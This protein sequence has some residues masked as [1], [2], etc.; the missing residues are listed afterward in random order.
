[1]QALALARRGFQVTVLEKDASF[2]ARRQGFGLTL[3][4]GGAALS[5]LG[6]QQAVAEASSWSASHFVFDNFGAIVAFWGPTWWKRAKELAERE[7]VARGRGD[8]DSEKELVEG[9]SGAV[10]KEEAETEK[11]RKLAGHNL[12]IPRQTL[13]EILLKALLQVGKQKR[14]CLCVCSCVC[15]FVC[16]RLHS[17]VELGGQVPEALVARATKSGLIVSV[18]VLPAITPAQLSLD[19]S[20]HSPVFGHICMWS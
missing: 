12:H 11:W 4:Q 7:S 13:R 8:G 16:L 18:L 14:R 6:V 19:V 9:G 5:R 10:N 15:V 20:A 1:M 17:F 2:L 3:Q